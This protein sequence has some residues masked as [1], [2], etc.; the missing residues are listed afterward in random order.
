MDATFTLTMTDCN[1]LPTLFTST[2]YS[3]F[4]SEA[5]TGPGTDTVVYTGLAVTD[6]D[7]TAANRDAVFSVQGFSQSTRGWFNVDP[8]TVSYH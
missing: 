2:A 3:F 4:V 1:D 6:G 7:G 5:I 8:A